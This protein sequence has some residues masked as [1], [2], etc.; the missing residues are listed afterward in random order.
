MT[1]TIE[2]TPEEE[3]RLQEEAQRAG[4]D[5]AAF[6]HW[7]IASGLVELPLPKTPS[8]AIAYWREA[9]VTGLFADRP[10]SPE[11]ARQLRAS[12]QGQAAHEDAA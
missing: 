9:G 8:E 5:T 7:L 1:L 2:L 10:D 6:A 3:A 11:F 4:V 12:M